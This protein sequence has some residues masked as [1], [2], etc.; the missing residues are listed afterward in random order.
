MKKKSRL[1][2]GLFLIIGMILYSFPVFSLENE[3]EEEVKQEEVI[4]E[5]TEEQVEE[6]I[7]END[8]KEE[9]IPV[10]EIKETTISYQ[11]HIQNIGWQGYK[12]NGEVSGTSHQSK[13]LEAIKIKIENPN[14]T[15]DIEYS[16]HVQDYGWMDFV[17]NDTMSGT[18][19]ESK[20]LEAIKIRL[21]GELANHYDVYYRVHAQNFG[22][23]TW[24]KNGEEA[25]TSGFSYRLEAIEIALVKKGEQ[26]PTRSD[27]NTN[28]PFV[29]N[30]ISY[31]THVQSYGWQNYVYNGDMSGTSHESKRLEAIKIKLGKLGYNGGIEYNTYVESI[32]WQGYVG[33]DQIAG[34]SGRSLRLE[35]IKIKLTGELANHYDIYYRVHVE[36]LGWLGW[37]K[38]D[39]IS[40]TAGYAYR[41]EAI[42]IQV[43]EK[44]K[45]APGSTN[46]PNQLRKIKY[47]SYKANNW[48]NYNYDGDSNN[49]YN[50]RMEIF[51]I[52]LIKSEYSGDISYAY[53]IYNKGWQ[54]YV[55]N[56]ANAST[57]GSKIEAIKIKLTGEVA[58]HYDIYYSA[59]ISNVGWTGWAKNDEN[60]GNVGYDNTIQSIKVML[61]EKN[62][63][64]PG[65]T[66][67]AYKE[68][69]MKVKYA[70][71]VVGNKWQGYVENGNI[72][73]TTGQ[74]KSLHAIKIKLN[75]KL[76]TGTISYSAHVSNV[77]WQD[78]VS[79]DT[80]IGVIGNQIE[81]IKIKL[82]GDLANK[83]D[84]YYRVHVATVGW[85]GWTSNGKEAG[86][87]QGGLGVEAIEIQLVEKGGPAP[88]NTDNKKTTEPFLSAHWE[89]K[90]GNKYYYDVLGNMVKGGSYKIGKTTHYFGPTGIYLGDR[91]LEVL[92]I[93]AHNG[94]VDWE[95]VANSGIY[96]VI[97]RI[98]ASAEY[99][100]SK[101][102]ENV[103][104]CKKYGIP[105]GI[106][107]YS[108]AE[109][110]SEGQA[111]G[112]FTRALMDEFD[113][114]PTL[115]IYLDLES[116]PITQFMGTT[117]YTAVVKGYYSIVP[118]AE[119][120]TYTYYANTALNTDYM[121]NNI[122]WI[123]DY[124]GQ[125]Y[126]TGSYKM[127]QYTSTGRNAGVNGDVDRSILYHK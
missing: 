29:K 21:T 108:Y 14:Y 62:S 93:S 122:T 45:P 46:N 118:E 35:A 30:L 103:A 114:H 6:E 40:G 49:N 126:Y 66:S 27:I 97:L 81:A 50:N 3:I 26:P 119:L 87:V 90:H 15:G 74:S 52:S 76:P 117:E 98:A 59:Y 43:V 36:N 1:I 99:R 71:Y 123:A 47:K 104:G 86:T 24:A 16:T 2:L 37:A 91:Q 82:T 18:S 79:D 64:P 65:D 73:G 25:G 22:W 39:T 23:M 60:C 101:L 13:R 7:D 70:S 112:R 42:E 12:K 28:K 31:T 96:G 78:F 111:Y 84:V 10:E 4:E 102:K 9:K 51:N 121:R 32:G 120:Y 94:V 20:R 34:T 113:M 5:P 85:M 124:R 48:T 110:Y 127:W 57:V 19:H 53:Y 11:T 80:Q 33:N 116:N 77:G 63:T 55:S 17:K 105:Y 109:N 54:N 67:N 100:D 8:E 106:Y 58:N 125:C 92:D 88:Q 115:G 38:N 95:A 107:I 68:E 72:S 75:K 83:Y 41:L 44:G 56:G 61:V 69:N 89:T